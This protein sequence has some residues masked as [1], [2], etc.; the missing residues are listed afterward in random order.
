[1]VTRRNH[2]VYKFS[3][4]GKSQHQPLNTWD[5]RTLHG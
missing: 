1:M 5:Y 3:G 4:F 2:N